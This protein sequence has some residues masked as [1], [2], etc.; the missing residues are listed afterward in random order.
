MLP[1]LAE[2]IG[3]GDYATDV[4]NLNVNQAGL[5][6][7]IRASEE[8]GFG[9]DLLA[10]LKALIDRRVADGLPSLIEAVGRS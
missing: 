4:S 1:A 8:Q 6:N 9:G 2:D 10:P 7:I 5:D 3:N